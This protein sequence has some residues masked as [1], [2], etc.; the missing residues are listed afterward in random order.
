MDAI[1]SKVQQLKNLSEKQKKIS[2]FKK[3][4]AD[5]L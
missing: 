2:E 5:I 3:D 1:E 4:I